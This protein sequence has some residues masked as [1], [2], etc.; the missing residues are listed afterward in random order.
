MRDTMRHRG[1][2]DEGLWRSRR[3]ATSCSATAA[4]RSSTSARPGARRWATRT[5]RSRSR[6]TARSTTTPSCAR[7]SSAAATRSARDCDTE[8]LVHLYEEHGPE[9]VDRLVGMFAFAIWDAARRAAVRS[10]ATGSG[11]KPLYWIDDGRRFAFASEIKALLAAPAA[12]R[13]RPGRALALPDVRRRAAAAHAVRR[14]L[15]AR[16]RHDH[17]RR[18]ATARASPRRYWDPLEH[19]AQ[20]DG[21][22]DDWEAEFRFRLERSVERRMMSDVPVGVFLSGGVD[23]STNVA[24]MSRLTD[25]ADQHV[26]DR[27]PRRRGVQRVRL[28][29]AGRRAVRHA[30]TT[31]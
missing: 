12:A 7:S 11:I 2:D 1:P 26:L 29:A 8:V 21:D 15:E 5:A 14:R 16:P 9:M 10:R 19:R 25:R 22:V 17:A 6:S 24:L 3:R 31:R 4:W 20:L 27:L 18:R 30:T 13:D 23:S 28:G